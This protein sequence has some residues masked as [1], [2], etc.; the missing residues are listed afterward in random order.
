MS[1]S[2]IMKA[3]CGEMHAKKGGK[4]KSGKKKGMKY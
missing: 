1:R 2:M 4:K 3:R